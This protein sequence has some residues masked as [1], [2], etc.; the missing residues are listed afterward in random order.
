MS[1]VGDIPSSAPMP[2]S[3]QQAAYPDKYLQTHRTTGT[4]APPHFQHTPHAAPVR[5]PATSAGLRALQAHALQDTREPPGGPPRCAPCPWGAAVSLRP[6]TQ[7]PWT[8][9]SPRAQ[10]NCVLAAYVGRER[11]RRAWRERRSSG[12]VHATAVGRRTERETQARPRCRRCARMQSAAWRSGRRS[13]P[14]RSRRR[15]VASRCDEA[16]QC[17][18]RRGSRGDVV[19]RR[20]QQVYMDLMSSTWGLLLPHA[21]NSRSATFRVRLSTDLTLTLP[22]YLS[23]VVSIACRARDAT[24]HSAPTARQQPVRTLQG[25]R[26]RLKRPST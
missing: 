2:R 7:P 12:T 11:A 25:R 17:A 1:S 22:Y 14:P 3:S 26:T 9:S 5:L 19:R 24:M 4:T 6:G 18:R 15:R 8:L 20:G 23:R 16:P 21:K 13:E 10:K